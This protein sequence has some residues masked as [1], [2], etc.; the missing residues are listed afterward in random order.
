MK[1]LVLRSRYLPVVP[2]GSRVL[3]LSHVPRQ[4]N[5]SPVPFGGPAVPAR[6]VDSFAPVAWKEPKNAVGK[7]Y[8]WL[9][10]QHRACSCQYRQ[11]DE[12]VSQGIDLAHDFWFGLLCCR[13]DAVLCCSLWCWSFR[14]G[15]S[16][17]SSSI[18]LDDC[19]RD[20]DE[21]DGSCAEKSVRSDAWAQMG[22]FH[23]LLR[24]WRGI[25]PL[26][27]RSCQRMWSNRP[28][29][30]VCPWMSSYCWSTTLRI[31]PAPEE[32]C[33]EPT[34]SQLVAQV[35]SGWTALAVLIKTSLIEAPCAVFTRV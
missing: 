15:S 24:Q 33:T 7:S 2:M 26:L 29:R 28:C 31:A 5:D 23:G 34:L 11:S 14:N 25:L 30:C 16:S 18:W 20:F 35:N 1:G 19:C 27:V 8:L 9:D 21:Q 6:P 22:C 10:W 13:D 12:L 17:R 3:H 4:K 32:D